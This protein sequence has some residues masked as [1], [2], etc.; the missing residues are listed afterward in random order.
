MIWHKGCDRIRSELTDVLH[1]R[2]P[3]IT[4][5]SIKIIPYYYTT[6]FEICYIN[7]KLMSGVYSVIISHCI[8][9]HNI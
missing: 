1:N 8:V 6:Y 2:V 7:V 4:T 5:G 9:A 3:H